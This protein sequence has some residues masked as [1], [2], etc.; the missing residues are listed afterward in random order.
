L[1]RYV[2]KAASQMQDD[3]VASLRLRPAVFLS[4][5]ELESMACPTSPR[6]TGKAYHRK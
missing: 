3:T 2:A 1:I 6:H 4:V 5:N